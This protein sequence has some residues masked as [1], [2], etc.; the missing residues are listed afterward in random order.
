MA[1]AELPR[2]NLSDLVRGARERKGLSQS[3]AHKVCGVSRVT[4]RMW[5]KG[6]WEQVRLRYVPSIA[7]FCDVREEDVLEIMG[8][9]TPDATDALRRARKR[10]SVHDVINEA[11]LTG[12]ETGRQVNGCRTRARGGRGTSRRV[13]HPTGS[14]GHTPRRRC[15]RGP[16]G[17]TCRRAA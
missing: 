11:D 10:G 14:R 9:L 7:R 2:N 13:A 4:Y 6:T 5:E 3:Q 16:G 17:T 8:I 15:R 12:W 1:L